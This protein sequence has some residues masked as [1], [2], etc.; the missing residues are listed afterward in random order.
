MRLSLPLSDA[1]PDA[2]DGSSNLPVSVHWASKRTTVVPSS[3]AA[4]ARTGQLV[5]RPE[6]MLFLPL[7]SW[8]SRKL[9]CT[10]SRINGL[11]A[12]ECESGRAPGCLLI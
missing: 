4:A 5:E 2:A 6:V 10:Q 1:D 3:T 7:V 12:S 9:G 8:N 11:H